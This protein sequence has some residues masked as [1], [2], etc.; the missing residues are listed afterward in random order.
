MPQESANKLS[1]FILMDCENN[2]T[3]S[4]VAELTV[5]ETQV[6]GK[7]RRSGEREQKWKDL[8]VGHSLFADIDAYLT[9]WNSPTP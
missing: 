3:A 6:A 4:S 8:L 5:C 1:N 2:D 9:N 7:K